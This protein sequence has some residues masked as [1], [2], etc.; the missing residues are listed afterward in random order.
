MAWFGVTGITE[1]HW[2]VEREFFDRVHMT[3]GLWLRIILLF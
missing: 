3:C 1:D 2:K